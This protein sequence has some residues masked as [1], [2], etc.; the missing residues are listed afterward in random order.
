MYPQ[1]RKVPSNR[2]FLPFLPRSPHPFAFKQSIV[3]TKTC[4]RCFGGT[5]ASVVTTG[6]T[7]R[8]MPRFSTQPKSGAKNRHPLRSQSPPK[9]NW[10]ASQTNGAKVKVFFIQP[11]KYSKKTTTT[12]QWFI[13]IFGPL[14]PPSLSHNNPPLSGSCVFSKRRKLL[15]FVWHPQWSPD[16]IQGILP[17]PPKK[18]THIFPRI[19]SEGKDPLPTILFDGLLLLAFQRDTSPC[20]EK[21]I[22]PAKIFC[23]ENSSARGDSGGKMAQ[24]RILEPKCLGSRT[25]NAPG[26][27]ETH[28]FRVS[29]RK[30]IYPSHVPPTQTHA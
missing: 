12:I 8:G 17:P 20:F 16:K 7:Y 21:K 1:K 2:W 6:I 4:S 24:E 11:K 22:P 9:K 25:W 23:R 14:Y 19:K 27:Q 15:Q 10:K 29:W 30:K 3:G 5:W 13:F 28:I 18:K 26:P